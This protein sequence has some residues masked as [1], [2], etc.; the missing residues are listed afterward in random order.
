MTINAFTQLKERHLFLTMFADDMS[1]GIAGINLH[2]SVILL[3]KALDKLQEFATANG[4]V[5]S[6]EKSTITVFR[7]HGIEQAPQLFL[8]NTALKTVDTVKILGLTFDS[9]LSWAPY[10][11]EL[12]LECIRRLNILKILANKNWGADQEILRRTYIAVV[13]SK[14]DYACIIYGSG[15]PSLCETLE[16]INNQ[17]ARIILGAFRTSPKASCIAEANLTTLSFR[18]SLLTANYLTKLLSDATNQNYE[19]MAKNSSNNYKRSF[20][21]RAHC[22]TENADIPPCFMKITSSQAPNSE[23]TIK[24]DTELLEQRTSHARDSLKQLF[25][26]R[27]SELYGSFTQIYSDASKFDEGVG[28]AIFIPDENTKKEV[29]AHSFYS[30]F[31]AEAFAILMALEYIAENDSSDFLI[32]T[33]SAS[34]LSALRNAES[35]NFLVQNVRE[36]HCGMFGNEAADAS[37]REA[38][39]SNQIGTLPV[40]HL[41]W[42]KSSSQDLRF[43]FNLEWLK[44]ANRK[45]KKVRS[46]FFCKSP[47]PKFTKRN[48]V[49]LNRLRIGHTNIT[50]IH[51]ITKDAPPKCD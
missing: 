38:A 6:S 16:T 43:N 19:I 2:T 17:A 22:I 39:K 3:Q 8:Y 42:R 46:S 47:V 5:F 44:I 12:K 9:N 11:K 40:C 10:I 4:F 15:T 28:C 7:K 36:N 33:D 18:R 1:V 25:R 51:L 50:H 34:C 45:I 24:I 26:N 27:I 20:L 49:V 32:C 23:Y 14:L 29:K 13:R 30:V 31:P 21:H 35:G 41:D 37:A 48:L